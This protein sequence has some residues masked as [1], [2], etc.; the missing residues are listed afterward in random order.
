MLFKTSF[1][2]DR[3]Q[4]NANGEPCFKEIQIPS[5][6]SYETYVQVNQLERGKNKRLQKKLKTNLRKIPNIVHNIL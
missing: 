1:F 3:H 6:V 2:A 4:I 5:D